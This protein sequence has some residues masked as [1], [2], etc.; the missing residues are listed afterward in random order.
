[1][2]GPTLHIGDPLIYRLDLSAGAA[3]LSELPQVILT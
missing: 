3:D 2:A 1:L